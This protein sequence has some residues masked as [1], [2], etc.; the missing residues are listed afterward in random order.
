MRVLAGGQL[1][2][3][4]GFGTWR[5]TRRP[6]RAI[7]LVA[8]AG[9]GAP[10][11]A[12][13]TQA[14]DPTPREVEVVTVDTVVNKPAELFLVVTDDSG[15]EV[16]KRRIGVVEPGRR[17]VPFDLD[18]AD[19]T[20]LP[21]GQYGVELRAVDESGSQA[22]VPTR[23]E[24]MPVRISSARPSSLLEPL[25]TTGGQGFRLVLAIAVGALAGLAIGRRTGADV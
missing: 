2:T 20:P 14:R 13:P 24:V 9:Y 21:P 8:P 22:G 17:T 18:G 5:V 11:V 7:D 16:T 4:R 6:D 1:I 19:G 23:L 3:D 12:S 15:T 10:L 25:P